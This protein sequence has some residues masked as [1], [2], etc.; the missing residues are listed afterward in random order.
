LD[1]G[2][3]GL[4][5]LLAI[6]MTAFVQCAWLYR[7]PARF[8]LAKYWAVGLI[9][10]LLGQAV[11]SLADAVTMGAKTNA[12]FWWL[13]ALIFGVT[14]AGRAAGDTPAGRQVKPL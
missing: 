5:A 9:A 11:Y 2:L 1:F 10:A 13:L 8:P 4:V 6:Y 3:P 7:N 14:T 12:A